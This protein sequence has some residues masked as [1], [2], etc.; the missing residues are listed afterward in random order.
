MRHSWCLLSGD[1]GRFVCLHVP[2]VR[3]R[4]RLFS[5]FLSFLVSWLFALLVCYSP[6]GACHVVS[7]GD[8]IVLLVG[9]NPLRPRHAVT[10][11]S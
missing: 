11:L 6:P 8:D 9:L 3:A 5:G 10:P 2:R 4:M 7:V 1:T